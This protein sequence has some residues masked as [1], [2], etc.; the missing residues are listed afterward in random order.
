M[1]KVELTLPV[2]QHDGTSNNVHIIAIEQEIARKFGGFSST[3]CIGGWYDE[4]SGKYYSDESLLVWTYV[5]TQAD[6]EYLKQRATEYAVN[7]QQ[8][9]LLVVVSYAEV[10][11]VAGT[12]EQAA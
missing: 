2:Q 9:T 12:R 5:D 7:L 8:I 6:V 10:S 1:Y 11:F 3:R 4:Q